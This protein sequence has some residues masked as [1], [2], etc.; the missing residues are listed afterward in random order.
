MSLQDDEW[1]GYV[2]ASLE[3]FSRQFEE[4]RQQLNRIEDRQQVVEASTA[5]TAGVV[6]VIVSL[7]VA[8]I[9]WA[10]GGGIK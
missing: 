10:A 8:G 9:S 2:K 6:A 4:T 1:R 5:K 7:V 3:T